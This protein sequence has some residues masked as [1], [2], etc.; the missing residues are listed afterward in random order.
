MGMPDSRAKQAKV[1]GPKIEVFETS[2]PGLQIALVEL[3]APVPPFPLVVVHRPY[4]SRFTRHNL[5][6]CMRPSVD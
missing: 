2:N 5:W 3:G 1:Q 6:H 4:V